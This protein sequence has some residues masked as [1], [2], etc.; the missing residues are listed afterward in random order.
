MY[1]SVSEKPKKLFQ[2]ANK[3]MRSSVP[4]PPRWSA[5]R[6]RPPAWITE[7]IS[8]RWRGRISEGR[9][10]KSDRDK[11]RK[12]REGGRDK[13]KC[14]GL[15]QEGVGAAANALI[16]LSGGTLGLGDRILNRQKRWAEDEF[17]WAAEYNG[18]LDGFPGMTCGKLV[19]AMWSN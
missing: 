18:A 9:G 14:A 16:I 12:G 3:R 17:C 2:G 1:G 11:E 19:D 10:E 7:A 6:P 5:P 15:G 8:R 13:H 4:A